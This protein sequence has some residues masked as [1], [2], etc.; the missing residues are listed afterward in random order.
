MKS[1]GLK[2]DDYDYYLEG[3]HVLYL[4]ALLWKWALSW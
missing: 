1:F 2:M 3:R 4:L